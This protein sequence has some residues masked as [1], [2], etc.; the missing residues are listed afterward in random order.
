MA[1]VW[2][3]FY[4]IKIAFVKSKTDGLAGKPKGKTSLGRS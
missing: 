3:Q 2:E 1:N 4:Q